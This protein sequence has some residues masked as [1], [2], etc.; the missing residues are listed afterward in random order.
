MTHTLAGLLIFCEKGY[1]FCPPPVCSKCIND[2]SMFIVVLPGN[3]R[4]YTDN[5][6]CFIALL[7]HIFFFSASPWHT[8]V[9]YLKAFD[10]F[11]KIALC[12]LLPSLATHF[13]LR[14]GKAKHWH[15][16]RWPRSF[17]GGTSVTASV[18]SFTYESRLS[19]VLLCRSCFCQE[20]GMHSERYIALS[21]CIAQPQM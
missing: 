11:P 3:P 13:N 17:H 2:S 1:I 19:W 14:E 4:S 16:L 15:M 8:T 5:D 6:S 18:Q 10:M 12:L 9:R 21:Y 20:T 7:R